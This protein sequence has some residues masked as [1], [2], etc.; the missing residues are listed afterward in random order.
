[1]ILAPWHF[2]AAGNVG[3]KYVK[4]L[5]VLDRDA[6]IKIAITLQ[7]V[8]LPFVETPTCLR[9]LGIFSVGPFLRLRTAVGSSCRNNNKPK[10][11]NKEAQRQ[12]GRAG[13]VPE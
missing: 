13:L 3:C 5:N 1:V 10:R 6:T 4:W 9:W 8:F 12:R 7:A 2:T 11:V